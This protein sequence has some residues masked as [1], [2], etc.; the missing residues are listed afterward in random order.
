MSVEDRTVLINFFFYFRVCLIPGSNGLVKSAV[1][2][3]SSGCMGFGG[4]V[5]WLSLVV[6]RKASLISTGLAPRV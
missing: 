3:L 1:K 4:R 6:I 2:V 5:D